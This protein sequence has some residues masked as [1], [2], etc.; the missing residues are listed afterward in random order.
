MEQIEALLTQIA[1]PRLETGRPFLTLSYA[2][3]LDGCVTAVSGQPLTLSGPQSMTMTH[4]LRAAHD[5]ILVGIGT[6]LADNPRLTVRLVDGKNPQPVVVDSRLRFPIQANLLRDHPLPPWI[7]ASQHADQDRQ[8][9]LERL[10]ARVLRLPADANGQVDLL[11]LVECLGAL[12]V[13][14]L[15]VEGGARI[16][17]S[18]LRQRLVDL[19]VLTVSPR[20]VGGVHAVGSLDGTGTACFPH[21]SHPGHAW[22]GEDLILWGR[23]AW[24]QP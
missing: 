10:G 4:R 18:F 12:G 11:A 8:R 2:Q 20:L 21:L 13:Q 23:L 1:G 17:T 22:L 9:A 24:G 6:L 7:A 3:S 14:R 19:L 15:M 5:A 16:I